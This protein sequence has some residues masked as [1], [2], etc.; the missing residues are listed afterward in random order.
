MTQLPIDFTDVATAARRIAPHVHRTP[1]VRSH[2]LDEI[3]GC[4]LVLKCENLQRIGAFKVR[5]AH[6]AVLALGDDQAARGVV[7]HS[8]GNHAAALSLAARTRGIPEIG[9]AHV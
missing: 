2:R 8:S 3:L 5:G 1:L 9:R 7:T 4:E 6:N